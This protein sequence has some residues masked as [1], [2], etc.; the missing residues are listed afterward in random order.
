MYYHYHILYLEFLRKIAVSV[1][2]K[3]LIQKRGCMV[4]NMKMVAADTY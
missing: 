2:S 3:N 4:Y 1:P